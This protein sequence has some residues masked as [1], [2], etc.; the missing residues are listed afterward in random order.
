MAVGD[1]EWQTRQAYK[2]YVGVWGVIKA[3][4]RWLMDFPL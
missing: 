1:A 2:R 3:H 4:L